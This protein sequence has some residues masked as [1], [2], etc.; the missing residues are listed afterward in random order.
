MELLVSFGFPLESL[1]F[2]IYVFFCPGSEL[3]AASVKP[4]ALTSVKPTGIV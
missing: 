2:G 4:Q 3:Q 1:E